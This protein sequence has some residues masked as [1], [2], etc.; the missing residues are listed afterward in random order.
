MEP[1]IKY[2]AV[3]EYN[4]FVTASSPWFSTPQEADRW[5]LENDIERDYIQ[6]AINWAEMPYLS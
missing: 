5:C 3:R 4:D 1:T 6:P 2:R